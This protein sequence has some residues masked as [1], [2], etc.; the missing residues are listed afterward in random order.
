MKAAARA[1]A[2]YPPAR[3]GA[4]EPLWATGPAAVVREG[5]STVT[6]GTL[7]VLV[8]PLGLTFVSR[9]FLIHTITYSEWSAFSFG[10]TLAALLSSF[11]TLG[12]PGAV[13]RNIPYAGSDDERRAFV[14]GSLGTGGGAAVARGL[15]L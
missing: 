9:V 8:G 12:L 14:H 5:L 15:L 6:R 4:Q 10:R 2:I 11:G 1:P 13:A 3:A 7:L